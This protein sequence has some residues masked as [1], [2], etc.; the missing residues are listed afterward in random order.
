MFPHSDSS[1]GGFPGKRTSSFS[2][3]QRFPRRIAD[4]TASVLEAKVRRRKSIRS[5]QVSSSCTTTEVFLD[6]ESAGGHGLSEALG[7][8][9]FTNLD[10]VR[11]PA[12]APS[13]I[14]PA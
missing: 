6:I 8:A 14:W 13:R 4:Q 3:I 1:R 2:G 11:N 7:L 10:V 5:I 12:L 9:G